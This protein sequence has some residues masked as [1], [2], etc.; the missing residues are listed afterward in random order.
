MALEIITMERDSACRRGA[1]S[2]GNGECTCLSREQSYGQKMLALPIMCHRFEN[3][4]DVYQQN[5]FAEFPEWQQT[6]FAAP[7]SPRTTAD[8]Q[9]RHPKYQKSNQILDMQK[10]KHTS[11]GSLSSMS[12]KHS[13]CDGKYE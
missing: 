7:S 11:G 5:E 4:Y 9:I 12:L 6:T 13:A 3:R 10:R 2:Y 1:A 8:A